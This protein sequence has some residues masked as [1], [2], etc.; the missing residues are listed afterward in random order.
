MM[1]ISSGGCWR[2]ARKTCPLHHAV[3][4]IMQVAK[5]QGIVETFPYVCAGICCTQIKNAV[6]RYVPR[7][8]SLSHLHICIS[9]TIVVPF[10]AFQ[11]PAYPDTCSRS[12]SRNEKPSF[13][14]SL[15]ERWLQW[16]AQRITNLAFHLLRKITPQKQC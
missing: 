2:W 14:P 5:K 12:C 3:L 15:C 11:T 16:C 7:S 10:A 4:P 1:C 6:L 9:F 13:K 8:A